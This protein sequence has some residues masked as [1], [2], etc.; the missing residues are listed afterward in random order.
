VKVRHVE[1]LARLF[2]ITQLDAELID[3]LQAESLA[4][5]SV[6]SDIRKSSDKPKDIVKLLDTLK[7]DGKFQLIDWEWQILPFERIRLYIVTDR[8]EREFLYNNA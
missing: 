3:F 6:I 1:C 7:R 4:S 8:V 2:Q 5:P